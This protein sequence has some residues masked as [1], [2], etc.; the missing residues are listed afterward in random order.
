MKYSQTK[1]RNGGEKRFKYNEAQIFAHSSSRKLV[2]IPR[3]ANL[4]EDV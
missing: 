3:V 4:A 2:W 1:F